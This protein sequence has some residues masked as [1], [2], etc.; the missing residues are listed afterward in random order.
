MTRAQKLRRL[1]LDCVETL[2]P[3]DAHAPVTEAA[4]AYAILTYRYVD[5]LSMEE[6]ADKLSLSRRQ[7]YREHEK[8]IEAIASLLADKSARP[9]TSS[10]AT[11]ITTAEG[12]VDRLRR[13]ASADA[14]P[15]DQ[16]LGSVI[17]LLAPLSAE[18]NRRIHLQ[19]DGPLPNIRADRVH[20]RQALINVLTYALDIARGDIN[21]TA[22]GEAAHLLIAIDVAEAEAPPCDDSSQESP[23][24]ELSIARALVTAQGGS[25]TLQAQGDFHATLRLPAAQ[26]EASILVIDDN[27]DMVALFRR[28]LGGHRVSV[29]GVSDSEQ[30][31]KLSAELQPQL[32]TL[33][34]MMPHLDGW[35]ILQQLKSRPGTRD[36]PVIVCSV[37]NE[38]R[39]ALSMGA[40]G[41]LTKPVNQVD[42]LAM[43]HRWLGPLSVAH[44]A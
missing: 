5:G 4:R 17:N 2:R 8:G 7:I 16:L 10:Q 15:A 38:S 25:L 34:V 28:F 6:I 21:V 36:I 29:I 20:A 12:E 11:A 24:M 44:E 35:D 19:V 43:A 30:A 37:L 27:A 41:Y 14:I 40:S 1:L 13:T 9:V 42:F 31:L 39:L 32:I 26:A 3:Q 23:C 18:A 33:D 22:N